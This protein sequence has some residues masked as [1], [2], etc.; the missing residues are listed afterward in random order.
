MPMAPIET[1]QIEF[2]PG[3]LHVYRITTANRAAVEGWLNDDNGALDLALPLHESA[4]VAEIAAAHMY[5]GAT[6]AG[7]E[8]SMDSSNEEVEVAERRVAVDHINTKKMGT[9]TASLA[10]DTAKNLCLGLGD[11]ELTTNTTGNTIIRPGS[12]ARLQHWGFAWES[13]NA[14]IRVTGRRMVSSGN[15]KQSYKKFKGS[16][17]RTV[18]FELSSIVEPPFAWVYPTEKLGD[19]FSVLT[20]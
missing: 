8:L 12:S 9:I 3:T 18:P 11:F 19:G 4:T 2:G 16:D 20:A 17:Y 14:D 13:E 7:T 6:E 15:I 10:E 5:M 1:D